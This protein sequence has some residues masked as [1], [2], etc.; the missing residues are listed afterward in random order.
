VLA[1]LR[2]GDAR[3]GVHGVGP[4]VVEQPDPLVGDQLAPVGRMALEAEPLGR[5]GHPLLGAAGE[6]DEARRERGW[7]GE[8]GKAPQR[9]G[10]RPPHELVAEHPDADHC[11]HP[12]PLLQAARRRWRGGEMAA[13]LPSADQ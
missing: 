10:V 2:R 12:I 11:A 3:L 6:R 1:G 5:R 9:R 7:V 8:R 13:T 4:A